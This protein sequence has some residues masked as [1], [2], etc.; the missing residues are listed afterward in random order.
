MSKRNKSATAV[1]NQIL[2]QQLKQAKL[3]RY[4][5]VKNL[6]TTC[7]STDNPTCSGKRLGGMDWEE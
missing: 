6:I 4:H 2:S 3:N 5:L 1:C 7:L